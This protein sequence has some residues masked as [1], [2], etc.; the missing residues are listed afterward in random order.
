MHAHYG[1]ILALMALSMKKML[2]YL[3]KKVSETL[4]SKL[5]ANYG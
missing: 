2:N 4:M 1:M 5:K 3:M